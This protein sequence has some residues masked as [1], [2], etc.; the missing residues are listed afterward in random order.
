MYK[1]NLHT[2]SIYCDGN[3]TPE[4]II[5]TAIE[6]EFTTLGFSSH[7]LYPFA[8]DW[9]I[10]PQNFEKYINEIRFLQEK[11]KNEIEIFCGFEVDYLPPISYPQ[12][13]IYKKFNPD[14]IIGSV[15]YITGK[16]GV[17]SVDSSAQSVLQGIE[18]Y[19]QGNAKKATQ[20]YFATQREMLQTG[21]FDI[22]GHIDVIRKRNDI[23]KLFDENSSWYKAEIKKTAKEIAKSGVIVEVN[24]G[25][26]ARKALNDVYPS[27]YFLKQLNKLDVPIMINSDAHDSKDL[28]CAFDIA[29]EK[30]QK[31]GYTEIVKIER[32]ANQIKFETIPLF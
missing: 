12:K 32:E 4:E 3:N 18:L 29:K 27:E 5:K 9:H 26:I 8:E 22:I 2:H 16:N 15:H 14:Y 30:I 31:A 23:L 17:A 19:F 10:S 6:K 11:Y 28:D 20:T 21:S 24:T 13:N 25:G 1:A 7:S